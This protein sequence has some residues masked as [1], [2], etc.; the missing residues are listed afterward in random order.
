MAEQI[1]NFVLFCLAV[2]VVPV[3]V[4]RIFTGSDQGPM[5]ND[6]EACWI[7]GFLVLLFTSVVCVVVWAVI[8]KFN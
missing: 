2:V 7:R 4:G 1:A 6:I 3:I 8:I 5:V